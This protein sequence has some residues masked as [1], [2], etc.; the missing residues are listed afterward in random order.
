MG[1]AI[2]LGIPL[3]SVGAIRSV[4][5]KNAAEFGIW[6]I[7]YIPAPKKEIEILKAM[8][9]QA[10]DIAARQ[11]D[12]HVLGFSAQKNRR[13]IE[14]LIAPYFRFRWFDHGLLKHL[15]SPDPAPFVN[16][17]LS[18]LAEESEWAAR[19][20]PTDL[21]SPLLLPEC[22]FEPE[23]EHRDLWRN[24]GAYGDLQ[25]VTGA[26]R[27]IRSFQNTHHR[28][29]GFRTFSAYK[30]VDRRDRIFDQDGERHGIAPFPRD[31]K[32]SYRIEPGFHFDVT[33][34]DGRQFTLT[35]VSGGHY[36]ASSGA[37]LNV[38]SHGF[39]RL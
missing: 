7:R 9:K 32:Y 26:E 2:L 27:A 36:A 11:N 28:K 10:L 19:V 18:T 14:N 31:W 33:H 30:W 13:D 39:V 15:R 6:S 21:S 38:D 16:C 5:S 29:V 35:D 22:S 37:H 24:A 8:V 4:L 3:E 23:H 25:N 17:L 1:T 34:L 12:S 20:K